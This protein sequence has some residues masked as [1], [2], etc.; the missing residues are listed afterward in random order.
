VIAFWNRYE[1]PIRLIGFVMLGVAILTMWSHLPRWLDY[2]ALI[3]LVVGVVT[4][5]LDVWAR[6]RR[7]ASRR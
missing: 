1:I 4:F 7:L 6:R 5:P 3:S 2:V